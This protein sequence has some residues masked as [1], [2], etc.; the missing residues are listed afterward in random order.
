MPQVTPYQ[1]SN[2][3]Q[4][5]LSGRQY[6]DQRNDRTAL[7]DLKSQEL[8]QSQQQSSQ[9][10]QRYSQEQIISARKDLADAIPDAIKQIQ[11]TV[12]AEKRQEALL[13]LLRP[14]VINL[15]DVGGLDESIA[16]SLLS[17]NN[18]L[19]ADPEA[20]E[21]FSAAVK[22]IRDQQGNPALAQ[23]GDKGG[24][25]I[26]PNVKPIPKEGDKP[27]PTK[28]RAEFLKE[29]KP[30]ALINSAMGRVQAAVK[31]PSAA[32]GPVKLC[33]SSKASGIMV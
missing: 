3:A 27:D 6:A 31:N 14:R 7:L 1:G 8:Q 13:A 20:P 18:E 16:Q 26:L 9:E 21:K 29:T 4:T 28:L 12:P 5:Y 33:I 22:E 15:N 25:R 23:F 10:Q 32:I 17:M 11:A 2:L 24:V 30:F 19:L